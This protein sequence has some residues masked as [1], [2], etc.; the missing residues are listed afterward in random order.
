MI[1]G[2]WIGVRGRMSCHDHIVVGCRSWRSE[3]WSRG[4]IDAPRVE[5]CSK[6][7]NQGVSNNSNLRQITQ[8]RLPL[9]HTGLY[10][11]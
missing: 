7:E 11:L 3:E 5:R 10:F 6:N 8:H 4:K 2:V 9:Y 1:D